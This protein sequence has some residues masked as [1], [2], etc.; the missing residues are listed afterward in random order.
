MNNVFRKRVHRPGPFLRDLGTL[1]WS[2]PSLFSMMRA[3]RLSRAFAEK[4]ML[5][6]TAVNQCVLC[7]RVHSEMAFDNGVP[8]EEVLTLLNQDL[9]EGRF[10]RE[11]EQTALLYAQHYAE[12]ERKPEPGRTARLEE[13]YGRE[14]AGDILLVLKIINFFNLCG[15]TFSAFTARFR[16]LRAEGSSLLF[17]AVF[18]LFSAPAILVFSLYAR[19]RGNRFSFQNR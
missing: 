6:T 8:R 2:L 4:L 15:N 9:G 17:E 13:V 11:E 12:T 14:K 7:A 18:F 16:G 5:A 3:R 10:A 1:L 19:L